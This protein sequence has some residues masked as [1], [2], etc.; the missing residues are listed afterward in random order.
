[1]FLLCISSVFDYLKVSVKGL[2]QKR[3]DLH[4]CKNVKF[5]STEIGM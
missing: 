1:M 3:T 4:C 5:A 2:N